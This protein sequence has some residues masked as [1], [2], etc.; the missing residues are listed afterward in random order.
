MAFN[1]FKSFGKNK[2]FVSNKRYEENLQNQ[3]LFN[4]ETLEQLYKHGVS[5]EKEQKVEFF[6]YTD[7]LEKAQ[8]LTNDLLNKGYEVQHGQSA[9]GNKLFV[10]TGWTVKMQ[11]D[12]QTLSEWSKHMCNVGYAHDCDFDGWGTYIE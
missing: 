11:M 4:V 3:F 6:F 8:N 12:K 9:G 7:T 10:I 2:Q 5:S 1:L